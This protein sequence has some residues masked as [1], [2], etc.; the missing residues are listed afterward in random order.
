M[1][2]PHLSGTPPSGSLSTMNNILRPL[3]LLGLLLVLS[4][5][6]SA[7]FASK[8]EPAPLRVGL[9][10]DLPPLVY[11]ENGE[12]KGLEIDLA[13]K[14]AGALGRPVEVS[15]MP[16]DTLL[17]SLQSEKVDLLMGG[18]TITQARSVQVSFTEPVLE[19][20]LMALI[21]S[22]DR[23]KL[24]TKAQLEN[25]GGQIGVMPG[26]TSDAYVQRAL[27]RARRIPVDSAKDAALVLQRRGI[28]AFVHDVPAVIWLFSKNEANT[29]PMTELLQR[30]QIGWAVRHEEGALLADVNRVLSGWKKDGTLNAEIL[31]W[32]PYYQK[33][34]DANP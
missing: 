1:T 10:P 16:W 7:P 9:T 23:E 24:G 8:N 33:L 32:L 3:S 27:P 14:L 26:T 29:A 20:G 13:R 30:E 22:S 28:D 5:C 17:K 11:L 12:L 15:T 25:F 31:R 19:S 34:L 4:G 21:R 18:L 2:G 6:A